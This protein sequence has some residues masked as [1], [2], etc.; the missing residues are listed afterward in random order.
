MEEENIEVAPEQTA[1]DYTWLLEQ[2]YLEEQEQ[3][4]MLQEIHSELEQV[5]VNFTAVSGEVEEVGG[6]VWLILCLAVF[7]FCWSCMRGWRKAVVQS[8]K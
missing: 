3:T 2:M 4:E 7:S 5:N 1:I 8:G 6:K